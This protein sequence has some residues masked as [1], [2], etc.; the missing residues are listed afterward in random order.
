MARYPPGKR[1]HV[2]DARHEGSGSVVSFPSAAAVS[3]TKEGLPGPKLRLRKYEGNGLLHLGAWKE[4]GHPNVRV[5]LFTKALTILT[6]ASA[7]RIH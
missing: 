6:M 7:L 2:G 4:L 5:F 1:S 3:V